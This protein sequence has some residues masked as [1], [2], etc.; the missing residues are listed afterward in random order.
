MYDYNYA[1]IDYVIIMRSIIFTTQGDYENKAVIVL[2]M[3]IIMT[4]RQ[5]S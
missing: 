2:T 1:T 4:R 5:K 3:I